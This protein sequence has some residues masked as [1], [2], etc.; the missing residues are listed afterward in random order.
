MRLCAFD[1]HG[2][3]YIVLFLYIFFCLSHFVANKDITYIV[4]EVNTRRVHHRHIG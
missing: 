3:V 2:S 4:M 1:A